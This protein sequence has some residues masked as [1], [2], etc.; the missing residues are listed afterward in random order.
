MAQPI[1]DFVLVDE[2]Q[3]LDADAY[4]FF[5]TIAKHVTVCLDNKQQLYERGSKPKLMPYHSAKGLTF[6]TV[7]FLDAESNTSLSQL[8][9]ILDQIGSR[10]KKVGE[11]QRAY[12]ELAFREL[13]NPDSDS[14]RNLSACWLNAQQK[15]NSLY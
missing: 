6:D 5:K 13:L 11:A 2:G 8:I 12:F 14:Y 9:V 7:A 10:A 1:Y 15:Y 4:D 3:D